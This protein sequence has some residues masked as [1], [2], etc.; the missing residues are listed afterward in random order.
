MSEYN[1]DMDPRD[2]AALAVIDILSAWR[3]KA[4]TPKET[5]KRLR[6]L[7]AW[8]EGEGSQVPLPNVGEHP[9]P[10][11][12][13][14]VKDR[15]AAV[16]RIFSH[17]QR[18]LDKPHA[19]LTPERAS[20]VNA[21]LRKYTEAQIKAAIDAVAGSE[22]HRE[23]RHDDLELICR[24][25]THVEKYLE[26]GGSMGELLAPRTTDP[27][28]IELQEAMENALKEG[29]GDQYDAANRALKRLLSQPGG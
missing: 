7:A 16:T 14:K 15:A 6:D 24:T 22:F 26:L 12:S 4:T 23:K 18:A 5:A 25:D 27:A 19:T 20:K 28:V 2:A 3:A 8:I 17:W 29:R 13:P 10:P 21:R 9:K 11:A 1:D